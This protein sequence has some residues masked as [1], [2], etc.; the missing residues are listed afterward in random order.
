[1]SSSDARSRSD[2]RS[3]GSRQNESQLEKNRKRTQR[4]LRI[5]DV[6]GPGLSG[7][8]GPAPSGRMTPQQKAAT[9]SPELVMAAS[10]PQDEG[11]LFQCTE[12]DMIVKGSDPYCPFCG[13]IFADGPLADESAAEEAAE[14]P[15]T[16]KPVE[17]QEFVRPE[18]FDLFAL[19]KARTR[20]RD[21]LYQE[22]L[23]GFAGSARLL[24]E[25][26]HLIS[27]VSSLGK[28]TTR[29]RRLV[30]SAWEAC[31][32]GDW[33]LVSALARQTEELMSP[34]IPD[35]VRSELSKAREYLTDAKAAG[36]DISK[37]VLRI[38]SAM[39]SLQA[40]DP[41]EALRLTKELMD[42]LRED[43]VSWGKGGPTASDNHF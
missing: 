1:M 19:L 22:A 9:L 40:D 14:T 3:V 29:A 31:R 38:K 37:Y 20:S 26:E 13:A 12:C 35:L 36:I 28:D 11:V 43:S 32:E 33:N 5:T 17:R 25:I 7:G 24:E 34:S 41:D 4:T 2:A 16:E 15:A 23:N 30:G 21:L 10:A 39:H 42:I 8:T 18:K 27:D 6:G